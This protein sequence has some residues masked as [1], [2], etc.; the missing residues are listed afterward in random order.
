MALSSFI[1]AFLDALASCEKTV[2]IE[3]QFALL[4]A[5]RNLNTSERHYVE[6]TFQTKLKEFINKF[7]SPLR[8][9]QCF[10]HNSVMAKFCAQ[11]EM[12]FHLVQIRNKLDEL[13]THGQK[14]QY[15]KGVSFAVNSVMSCVSIA[16]PDQRIELLQQ[17]ISVFQHQVAVAS[18]LEQHIKRIDLF[19]SLT[20]ENSRPVT[21]LHDK[22]DIAVKV[23]TPATTATEI[24]HRTAADTTTSPAA[25]CVS[26]TAS[27]F[28]V[29]MPLMLKMQSSPFN[30]YERSGSVMQYQAHRNTPFLSDFVDK[31]VEQAENIVFDLVA[32]MYVSVDDL[33]LTLSPDRCHLLLKGTCEQEDYEDIAI[34]VSEAWHEHITTYAKNYVHPWFNLKVD[35]CCPEIALV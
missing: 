14:N 28:I 8:W 5:W 22:E 4:K 29:Q 11:H 19:Q 34:H 20:S 32:R 9:S 10:E 25:S 12:H 23:T 15:E 6:Y 16:A 27:T 30:V 33:T 1:Q 7:D 26:S 17:A 2:N 21:S 35:V 31:I 18:Q 24:E 3:N 13:L